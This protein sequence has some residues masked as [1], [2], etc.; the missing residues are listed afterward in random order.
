MTM[1]IRIGNTAMAP[2]RWGRGVT[3]GLAVVLALVGLPGAGAHPA[4]GAVLSVRHHDTHVE[5][6]GVTGLHSGRRAPYRLLV[7][8]Q[9]NN[10]LLVYSRGT[11]TGVLLNPDGSPILDPAS[12][13]PIT[14]VTPLAN[15]PGTPPGAN[16]DNLELETLLLAEG[17]ALVAS[18]YKPE[19]RFLEHGLLGWVVEDGLRDTQE[20]T[21]EAR[22]LLAL[23]KGRTG[24]TLLW[25]RSQGTLISLRL[26]EAPPP[27]F[28]GVLA[29]CAVGAGAPRNWDLGLGFALAYDVAFGW[30]P[31]WG[32][33]EGGDLPVNL[34]FQQ[35]V[36]PH[37]LQRLLAPQSV[38]LFEFIRIV[39]GLPFHGFYP[40]PA[41]PFSWLTAIMLFLT[42][43]RAD[44]ESEGKANGRVSQNAGHVYRVTPGERGYLQQLG[45]DVD[46]LLAAMNGRTDVKAGAQARRYVERFA[47]FS[48]RIARPVLSMHTTID[49][50]VIPANESAYR[51]TV[52]AARRSS[53]LAQAF[54][55]GVGHCTFTPDQWH[56]A[57]RA[58]ESW[59]ETG[60][61]PS[62]EESF[63]PAL[64]FDHTFGPPAWPQ[65]PA[66]P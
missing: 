2:G 39:N 65:P 21:L 51:D 11:G 58:M 59:L 41:S 46:D 8:D 14:G 54:V 13:L 49:G 10:A 24:R 23:N 36:L 28:D 33:P 55:T 40:S 53:R 42:E 30:D 63:P 43:V 3:A 34:G 1:H 17:Y 5:Y 19:S 57:I 9:W 60:I 37:I 12:G 52:D 38:G 20:V 44:I 6:L 7:P 56:T 4:H 32:S 66:E 25:S 26:A 31:A 61:K 15:V 62:G 64:G 16:D 47:D 18:D 22:L 35:S 48:G 27:L 45:V 29:G 50:L